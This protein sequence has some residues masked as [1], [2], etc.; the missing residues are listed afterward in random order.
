MLKSLQGDEQKALYASCLVLMSLRSHVRRGLPCQEQ[1]WSHY[2]IR[3]YHVD[4]VCTHVSWRRVGGC[5]ETMLL[6]PSL[7]HIL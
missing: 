7:G 6:L 4:T 3:A 2:D 5:A 1:G